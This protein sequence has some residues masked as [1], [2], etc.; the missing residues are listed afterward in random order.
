MIDS[1]EALVAMQDIAVNL[2]RHSRSVDRNDIGLFLSAYRSGATVSY[3]AFEGAA[4]DFGH[5]LIDA[6]AGAPT[7]LHRTSNM[8]IRVE[9]EDQAC[10]ESYVIAYLKTP[11]GEKGVQRLVGGRYLDRHMRTDAGWRLDHRTYVMDWNIN[12]PSREP[13]LPYAGLRGIQGDADPGQMMLASFR[14]VHQREDKS[15]ADDISN[16]DQALTRLALHDLRCAYARGVDR[17]DG[18]LLAS[19]FHPGATVEGPF[20]GSAEAFASAVVEHVRSNLATC[21]HSIANE[22]DEIAGD[23]AVG[24]SYVLAYSA[25]RGDNARETLT[26]GRYL[27]RYERRSGVWKIALRRYVEDWAM[28]QTLTREETGMYEELPLRGALAP[29][30]PVYALWDK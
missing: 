11:E 3:G 1:V 6:M 13:A 21:A 19:I 16:L 14:E 7:T 8:W 17:A 18:G 26:G 24:E 5:A 10:S 25:T 22:Y 23:V 30:D 2:A 20:G 27:D 29:D 28:T 4:S 15:M 12:L 9:C